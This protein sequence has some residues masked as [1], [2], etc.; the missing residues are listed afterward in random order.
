MANLNRTLVRESIDIETFE[1]ERMV[2][3]G[4]LIDY[5]EKNKTF[6]F[7][8]KVEKSIMRIEMTFFKDSC[9]II[10]NYPDSTTEFTLKVNN[11]EDYCL[12]LNNS[13]KLFFLTEASLIKYDEKQIKL[14]Y[15]L[16]DKNTKQVISMNEISIIGEC[17]IC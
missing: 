1:K 16:Y 10:Q 3:N 11:K 12:I 7:A 15:N 8:F 4:K 17:D 5:N 14:K 13:Y 9:K 6:K 2:F